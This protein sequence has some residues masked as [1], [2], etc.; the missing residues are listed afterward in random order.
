MLILQAF[1]RPL[2]RGKAWV[3]VA[4]VCS[5]LNTANVLRLSV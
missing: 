3:A 5:M 4:S 1:C 2:Y